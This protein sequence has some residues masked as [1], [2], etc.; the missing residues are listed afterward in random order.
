MAVN[1][2]LQFRCFVSYLNSFSSL[3]FSKLV[4][5]VLKKTPGP[6]VHHTLS[7]TSHM[8]AIERS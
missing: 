3:K 8:G 1:F 4:Y 5:H 2:I 6:R 7:V